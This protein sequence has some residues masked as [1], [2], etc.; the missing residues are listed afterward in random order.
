MDEKLKE[1]YKNFD[2][3]FVSSQIANEYNKNLQSGT[4]SLFHGMELFKEK[5]LKLSNVGYE[6]AKGNLFEYIEGA[7]FARNNA[8]EGFAPYDKFAV[9]DLSK[10]KGGFGEHTAPDDF[11]LV[12]NDEVVVRGQAKVN[13]DPSNTANNFLNNKYDGMQRITT[14]DTID[15]VK[16]ALYNKLQKGEISQKQ[17]DEVISNIRDGLTDDRTGVSSGGT[18][19]IELEKFRGKDGKIDI[20]EV[21]KYSNKLELEQ[22]ALEVGGATYKGAV[23]GAVMSSVVTGVHEFFEVYK[24]RKSLKEALK[25]TGL[26]AKSG[27]LRGGVTGMISSAIRIFSQKNAI[28]VLSNSSAATTLA[29]G[30]VDCGVSIY[31]YING[32]IDAKSLANEIRGTVVKSASAYYFTTALQVTLGVGSGVFIPMAI[33]SITSSMIMATKSI[34]D[35]AKLNVEQYRRAT[36]LLNQEYAYLKDYRNQLNEAFHVFR[37]D[38]QVAFSK[39]ISDFDNAAF[40]TLDYS[41]A[42]SSIVVLS[43]HMQYS[44]QHKEFEEFKKAMNSSETFILK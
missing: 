8:N 37:E 17:Y 16:E 35:Q 29:A 7:K 36:E 39:F 32:E 5:S 42:I 14:V 23:A 31:A 38:R 22:M 44:L 26:A 20:D 43:N 10:S 13:N 12:R 33:Y 24:E 28:P 25:N 19:R 15:D 11:R 27:A 21:M 3:N 2:N 18:T 34:I 1:K 30:V 41:A 4:D 40:V 9:T 6:Q